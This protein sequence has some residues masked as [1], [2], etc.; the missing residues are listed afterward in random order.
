LKHMIF[1]CSF[2]GCMSHPRGVWICGKYIHLFS[3]FICVVI[4]LTDKGNTK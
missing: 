4:L 1:H 3:F 2:F